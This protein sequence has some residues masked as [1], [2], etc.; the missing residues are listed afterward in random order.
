MPGP[1]PTR[2]RPSICRMARSTVPW[3]C[4]LWLCRQ[5]FLYQDKYFGTSHWILV[6]REAGHQML[7]SSFTPNTEL[8]NFLISDDCATQFSAC[9]PPEPRPVPRLPRFPEVF[10][11]APRLLA[12]RPRPRR[13]D[14]A[15]VSHTRPQTRACEVPSLF[16]ELFPRRRVSPIDGQPFCFCVFR[17]VS[18][19]GGSSVWF[20]SHALHGEEARQSLFQPLIPLVTCN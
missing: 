20:R 8:F 14:C 1:C 9:V 11:H 5:Q 13:R 6:L 15:F 2:P 10:S 3:D 19:V 12:L 18:L 17:C 16:P 4:T 7:T